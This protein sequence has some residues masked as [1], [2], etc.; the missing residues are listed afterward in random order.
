MPTPFRDVIQ[1]TM[2]WMFA[3]T[4]LLF[5]FCTFGARPL[6]H[7]LGLVLGWLG[8]PGLEGTGL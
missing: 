8:G 6:L 7:V 2:F 1:S 3:F 5:L 4:F